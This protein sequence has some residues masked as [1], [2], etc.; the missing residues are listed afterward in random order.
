VADVDAENELELAAADDQQPVETLAANAADP[1]VHLRVRVRRSHRRTND[2]DAASRHECVERAWEVRV[3]VVDQESHLSPAAVEFHQQVARL[4]QHPGG[5]R[6]GRAG[7]VFDL[8]AADREEGENV[9]AAQPDRMSTVKKSQA[10][11]DSPCAR[12]KLRHDCRPR[13]GAGGT[14]ALAMMLRTEVAEM[15]MPG[16]RSSP[17]IRW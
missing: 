4:P 2:L 8:A 1:A 11:I 14:P 5:G 13:C 3:A 15:A 17:T 9:D 16:L 12:K 10:R 7:D 6:L